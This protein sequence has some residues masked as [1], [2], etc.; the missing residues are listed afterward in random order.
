MQ[1]P[2]PCLRL[3]DYGLAGVA[4]DKKEYKSKV[5]LNAIQKD[6]LIGTILGAATPLV[7]KKEL[8]LK[9]LV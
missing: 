1:Q 6:I 4:I 5:N 7:L 9:M 2:H 8:N 3:R